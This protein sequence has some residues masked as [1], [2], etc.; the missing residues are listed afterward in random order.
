[1]LAFGLLDRAFYRFG[2]FLPTFR[3]GWDQFR[4]YAFEYHR[5]QLSWATQSKGPLVLV[6]GSSIAK[7][8]VQS[9]LLEAEIQKLRSADAPA[10]VEMLVH[11]S[12]LPTDL[13]H[14]LPEIVA[15]K[16][17]AL[18]YITNP[19]DL[20]LERYLPGDEVGPAFAQSEHINYLALRRPMLLYYPG[21]FAQRFAKEL[22][23][24]EQVRLRL[25]GLSPALR[26]QSEW[27]DA[28]LFNYRSVAG[29]LKSYLNYQGIDIPEG[30]WREGRTGACFS[31][32]KSAVTKESIWEVPPDLIQ[33]T[34]F[35]L[36]VFGFPARPFNGPERGGQTPASSRDSV[37]CRI[38][39]DAVALGTVTP[40]RSGWQPM[41]LPPAGAA[42]TNYFVLLSHVSPNE[43]GR[44]SVQHS[45]PVT[46]GKGV[47]LPGQFGLAEPPRNDYLVRRLA[48][49]DRWL[50]NL[51]DTEYIRDFERR[52]HPIDWRKPENVSVH[53]FNR[54]RM[55]KLQLHWQKFQPIL[56]AEEIRRIAETLPPQTRLIIVNNPE[57]PLTRETYESSNWYH[58]YLAYMR[59]LA[60]RPNVD[61]Y[62]FRD[63]LPMQNFSDAHHLT[64][65]GL[66]KMAPLYANAIA[67]ALSQ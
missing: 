23:W 28:W 25:H 8:S 37:T 14:Y 63:R 11:A 17:E 49:E 20:D 65:G 45:G 26:F 66:E 36:T 58:G 7:Y 64:F 43:G 56:P 57:N 38:P 35:K 30:L 29:P 24:E 39:P 18:V 32:P 40:M 21:A 3:G 6:A 67:K 53:Q 51:T 1:M 42:I 59:K 47:R 50:E 46:A 19:A 44:K 9:K 61:F 4:W 12:M 15:L 60:K 55:A 2:I 52:V 10:S 54:L 27:W 34:G 33:G 48:L 5:R 62:D 13:L 22:S 41:D 16:P 31:L